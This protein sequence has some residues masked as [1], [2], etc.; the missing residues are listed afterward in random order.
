M[1][2]IIFVVLLFIFTLQ[3]DVINGVTSVL[4][5]VLDAAGNLVSNP[6]VG[7]LINAAGTFTG[8]AAKGLFLACYFPQGSP[9]SVNGNA[10]GGFP[11]TTISF[12]NEA[13]Q[14]VI[15]NRFE[16]KF[17]MAG[18]PGVNIPVHVLTIYVLIKFYDRNNPAAYEGNTGN[19]DPTKT[20]ADN[21]IYNLNYKRVLYA[22]VHTV[23]EKTYNYGKFV[24]SYIYPNKVRQTTGDVIVRIDV[25]Y[26]ADSTRKYNLSKIKPQNVTHYGM[27]KYKDSNGE[28]KVKFEVKTEPFLPIWTSTG[29]FTYTNEELQDYFIKKETGEKIYTN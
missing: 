20:D 28:E 17:T 12:A 3:T 1:K 9:I 24:S 15:I 13:G 27:T 6:G 2:F 11:F 14:T 29:Y 26:L 19:F 4:N 22:I 16:L 18:F 23:S 21:Y 8:E 5:P 7:K 25:T 10:A